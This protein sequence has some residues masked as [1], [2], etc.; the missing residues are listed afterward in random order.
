MLHLIKRFGKAGNCAWS[1]FRFGAHLP[2]SYSPRT[3]R[4]LGYGRQFVVPPAFPISNS[5]P[6]F[7][8]RFCLHRAIFVFCFT[9]FPKNSK[10]IAISGSLF[11]KIRWKW[12]G[13]T[14]MTSGKGAQQLLCLT[15]SNALLSC[16]PNPNSNVLREKESFSPPPPK[17]RTRLFS[18]SVITIHFLR[19]VFHA[20]IVEIIIHYCPPKPL[21]QGSFSSTPLITHLSMGFPRKRKSKPRTSWDPWQLWPQKPVRS[22][23]KRQNVGRKKKWRGT[24]ANGALRESQPFLLWPD[25]SFVGLYLNSFQE[26]GMIILV[27]WGNFFSL[28]WTTLSAY[29]TLSYPT[30]ID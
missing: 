24:T 9:D 19:V 13:Q 16:T 30:N 27:Q 6:S 20:H 26:I 2:R 29:L 10:I 23:S 12:Q 22:L 21:L 7:S 15:D 3:R 28:G 11:P 25:R 5:S 4:F 17:E 8:F 18:R 1:Q 14:L